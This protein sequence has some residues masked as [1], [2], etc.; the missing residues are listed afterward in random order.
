MPG[1]NKK[2]EINL[3]LVELYAGQGMTNQ[4]IA[5]ALSISWDT[6]N[7]RKKESAEFADAYKRGKAKGVA[8]ITN[9]LF[10]NAKKGNVAAQIYFLKTQ[11]G[12]QWRE[13]QAIDHT[14]GDGS[15]TPKGPSLQMVLTHEAET[16]QEAD[17]GGDEPGH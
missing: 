7:R 13:K 8:T 3:K 10:A 9:A 11:G 16:P 5:D 12:E 1:T 15:M 14:S 17:A 4:Q 6:L 2:I